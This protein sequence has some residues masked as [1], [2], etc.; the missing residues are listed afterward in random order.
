M[1]GIH[2]GCRQGTKIRLLFKNGRKPVITKFKEEKGRYILTEDGRFP[3][4]ELRAM[5]IYKPNH[6]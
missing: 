1:S 4:K 5:T 2:T 3:I 6:A